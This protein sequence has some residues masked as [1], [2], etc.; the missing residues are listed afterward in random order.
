MQFVSNI[1]CMELYQKLQGLGQGF[2]FMQDYYK[3]MKIGIIQANV[4]ED[5]QTIVARFLNR[6][7]RDIANVVEL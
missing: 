4:V 6:L 7:N 5:R 1:Y 3:E 2:K